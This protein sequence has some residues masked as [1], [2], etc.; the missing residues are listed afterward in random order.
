[1]GRGCVGGRGGRGEEGGLDGVRIKLKPATRRPSSRFPLPKHR[2]RN[3]VVEPMDLCMNATS[4][5]ISPSLQEQIKYVLG[6]VVQGDGRACLE[7]PA[8][9]RGDCGACGGGRGQGRLQEKRA[10]ATQAGAA[11]GNEHGNGGVEARHDDCCWGG[12]GE[13][14]WPKGGGAERCI[15]PLNTCALG[16]G[17]G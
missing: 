9:T 1:M 5:D 14:D 4:M 12:V 3:Q 16:L 15:T 11:H 8:A 7:R 17:K 2:K 13:A 10:G 6:L